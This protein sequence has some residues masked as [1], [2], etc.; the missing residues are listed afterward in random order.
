MQIS[1]NKKIMIMLG[2][3]VLIGA[4][5]LVVGIDFEI[6]QY[7]MSSKIRKL[8]LMLIDLQFLNQIN[9]PT[10]FAPCNKLIRW[11]HK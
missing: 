4:L 7:Q 9:V 5:Y 6:F 11:Y 3:T 2:V 8:V 10:K 1:A